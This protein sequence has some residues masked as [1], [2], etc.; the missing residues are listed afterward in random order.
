MVLG[1]PNLN[2][3]AEGSLETNVTDIVVHP[4]WK[5]ESNIFEADIAIILLEF[6]VEFNTKIQ[7]ISLPLFNEHYDK[8][9]EDGVV[10]SFALLTST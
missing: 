10:V 4:F 9:D 3:E 2:D 7:P 5:P 1:K 6:M 8:F